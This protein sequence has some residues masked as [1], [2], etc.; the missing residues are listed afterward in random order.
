[1]LW[2][3]RQKSCTQG[4]CIIVFPRVSIF[5]GGDLRGLWGM[6]KKMVPLYLTVARMVLVVPIVGLIYW[7][8]PWAY[9]CAALL[10]VAAGVT[11]ALDG[12][13]S[14][15]WK[16]ESTAGALLDPAA[17]KILTLSVLVFLSYLQQVE[18]VL[19][20]LFMARDIYI[21]SLRSMAASKGLIL[22]AKPLAKWKTTLQ[23]VGILCLLISGVWDRGSFFFLSGSLLLWICVLMSGLSAWGYTRDFRKKFPFVDFD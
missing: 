8:R 11:D 13:L 7:E 17:D 2:T 20:V 12:Y 16:A 21:T 6:Q 15:R 3:G 14:R 18:P 22:Y 19:V 5:R 23:I 1:M 4:G 10:W 9:A